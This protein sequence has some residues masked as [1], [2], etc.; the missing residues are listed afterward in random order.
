MEPE[1]IFYPVQKNELFPGGSGPVLLPP[2]LV[3]TESM[4]QAWQPRGTC[5]KGQDGA[6]APTSTCRVRR[7][8]F[9]P[10]AIW[11]LREGND[12]HVILPKAIRSRE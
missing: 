4:V 1:K 8:A 2:V 5:S 6:R 7:G 10:V 12:C 11:S 9:S 3:V